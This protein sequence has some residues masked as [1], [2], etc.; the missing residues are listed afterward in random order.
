MS[1]VNISK[2]SPTSKSSHQQPRIVINFKSPSSQRSV[3]GAF[4]NN[5]Y[6]YPNDIDNE[7]VHGKSR[8]SHLDPDKLV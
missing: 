4:K 6:E 3:Q 8:K 7:L 5:S 1:G 2:M